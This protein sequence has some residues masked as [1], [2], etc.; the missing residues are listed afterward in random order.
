MTYSEHAR[1]AYAGWVSQGD[2]YALYDPFKSLAITAY[3]REAGE[4]ISGV[5]GSGGVHAIYKLFSHS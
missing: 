1:G 2:T 4:C 5:G 3:S